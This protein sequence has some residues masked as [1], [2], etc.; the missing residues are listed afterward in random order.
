MKIEAIVYA[1][2]TGFT[3]QYAKMLAEKT[4]VPAYTLKEAEGKISARTPVLYMSWLMAGILVDYKK[5]AEKMHIVAC[6][7]VG[8]NATDEQALVTKKS[9]KIPE[10]VPLFPLQGG[11]SPDRL[12]GMYK[13]MMKIVTKVL[14]KKI[15]AAENKSDEEE[16]MLHTLRYGGSFVK[17]ENLRGVLAFLQE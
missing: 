10:D 1:S 4:G 3:A 9:S 13:F 8:L 11:Y 16:M 12:K 15:S 6:C 5:A 14:I 17:E 7:A 2:M